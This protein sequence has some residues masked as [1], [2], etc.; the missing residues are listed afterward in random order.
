MGNVSRFFCVAF[1][2]LLTLGAILSLLVATLSGVVSSHQLHVVQV[3][4]S[5]LSIDPSQFSSALK[6]LEGGAKRDTSSLTARASAG[7][8]SAADLGF[9]DYYDINLWGYCYS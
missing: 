5:G 2:I 8:I 3:D 4:V 1:P 6:N 9:A 7:N